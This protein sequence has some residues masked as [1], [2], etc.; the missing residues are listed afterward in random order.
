MKNNIIAGKWNEFRGKIGDWQEKLSSTQPVK[1]NGNREEFVG[2]LQE[3]YGYDKEK[4]ESELEKHYSKIILTRKNEVW[5]DA[6]R[7]P[8]NPA[9]N[10]PSAESSTVPE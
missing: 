1:A 6:T 4:A 5:E 7:A 9:V 10:S 8:N 2:I 3:R